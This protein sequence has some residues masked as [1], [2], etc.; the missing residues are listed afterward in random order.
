M[1]YDFAV[2][3]QFV[4]TQLGGVAALVTQVVQL[5]KPIYQ[6]HQYQKYFDLGIAVGLNV[7]ICLFWYVDLFG[8]LGFY[9]WS[10][11]GPLLTG[12][13]ASLGSNILHEVVAILV[14]LRKGMPKPELTAVAD[15]CEG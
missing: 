8:V 11:V 3:L 14:A 9:M 7:G 5:V 2:A 12:L 13:V 1:D 10:F 4:L 15:D 6:G